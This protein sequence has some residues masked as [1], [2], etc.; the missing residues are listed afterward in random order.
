V[1]GPA[2]L[3]DLQSPGVHP[4]AFCLQGYSDYFFEDLKGDR[5]A[6][7]GTV[8]G[9]MERVDGEWARFRA[10]AAGLDEEALARSMGPTAG[11]Y[12]D[13]S[14][15]GLVLHAVD[16]VIHHTAEIGVLRDLYRSRAADGGLPAVSAA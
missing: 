14:Y 16:E 2:K 1:A 3:S 15:H 5:S 13:A 8:A 9:A 12:A 6:W 11:P 10:H 4:G 7:P